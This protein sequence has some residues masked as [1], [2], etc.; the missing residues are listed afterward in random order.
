M[1]NIRSPFNWVGSK[2]NFM[3]FVNTLLIGKQYDSVH[4]VFMG[5]GNVILNLHNKL[6]DEFYGNDKMKMLPL[7]FDFLRTHEEKFTLKDIDQVIKRWDSF[8]KREYYFEFRDEWNKRYKELTYENIDK[9]FVVDTVILTKVCLRSVLR[10]NSNDEFNQGFRGPNECIGRFKADRCREIANQINSIQKIIQ[11]KNIKTTNKDFTDLD[12]LNKDKYK[13]SLVIMDP[14]YINNTMYNKTDFTSDLEN[15]LYKILE[16]MEN[17]FMYFNYIEHKGEVNEKLQNI[18]KIRDDL[19][20]Y[21]LSN[22]TNLNK[23]I[24][25]KEVIVTNIT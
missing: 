19:K 24:A 15:H 3:R 10:F 5:G 4:D 22:K 9:A 21:N 12:L 13:N 20:V 6:A 14:P 7:I 11:R 8:S 16:N 25:I 2:Y 1:A 17:D 18:L 23:E